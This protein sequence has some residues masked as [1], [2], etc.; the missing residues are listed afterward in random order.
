MSLA[1]VRIDEAH[2]LVRRFLGTSYEPAA[3]AYLR[4]QVEQAQKHADKRRS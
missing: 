2:R 1:A 4:A 3:L